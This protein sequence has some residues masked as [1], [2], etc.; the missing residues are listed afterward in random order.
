MLEPDLHPHAELN[1]NGDFCMRNLP[2]GA[3]MLLTGPDAEEALRL[4]DR[5]GEPLVIEIQA[6]DLLELGKITPI[7]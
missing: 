4:V 1:K 3:Y 2:D 6:G 7:Q 5:D